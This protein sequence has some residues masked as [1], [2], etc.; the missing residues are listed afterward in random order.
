MEADSNPASEVRRFSTEAPSHIH[1]RPR[2]ATVVVYICSVR[3]AQGG[4][5]PHVISPLAP[6]PAS[7][8]VTMARILEGGGNLVSDG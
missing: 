4:A 8:Q 5:A 2:Y 1:L 6:P 3:T 7:M